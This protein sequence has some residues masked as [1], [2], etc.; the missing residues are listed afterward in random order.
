MPFICLVKCFNQKSNLLRLIFFLQTLSEFHFHGNK[1][2]CSL[3]I[4][5]VFFKNQYA[6]NFHWGI[7]FPIRETLLLSSF[8]EYLIRSIQQKLFYFSSNTYSYELAFSVAKFQACTEKGFIR[9]RNFRS[10]Y[11]SI[12]VAVS[13]NTVMTS[14]NE[15]AWTARTNSV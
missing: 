11:F 6:V 9:I 3:K 14:L 5:K 7:R 4:P 1:F 15:I 8:I 10:T 13:N 12:C 2:L